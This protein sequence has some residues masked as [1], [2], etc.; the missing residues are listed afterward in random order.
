MKK[1]TFIFNTDTKLDILQV[2]VSKLFNQKR[3]NKLAA[4]HSVDDNVWSDDSYKEGYT[5]ALHDVN[6]SLIKLRK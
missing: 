4:E 3:L 5:Q 2:K 6:K 1:G